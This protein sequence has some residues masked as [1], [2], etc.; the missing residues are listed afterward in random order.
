MDTIDYSGFE[1]VDIRIGT[2]TGA[3]VP[4]WSHWVMRLEVDFGPSFAKATDGKSTRICFSGIM[5]FFKPEDLIGRQFPFV[6]NLEP[7]KMGPEHEISECMMLMASP[8]DS[9]P[10][11]ES[12]NVSPVLFQL[13]S[14][15]NNGTKVR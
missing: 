3:A 1:K 6:T 12:E 15:V 10:E 4:E 14:K 5:K 13:Q 7:R 8:G 2:V 9:L 11:E